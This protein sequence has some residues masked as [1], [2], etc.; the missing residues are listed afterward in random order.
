VANLT[1][2][3]EEVIGTHSSL[4]LEERE[5]EDL[6]VNGFK[7]RTNFTGQIIVHD[8]FE[9][10][11]V[12]VIGPW[13]KHSKALV[14]DALLAVLQDVFLEELKVCFVSVDGVSQVVKLKLFLWV[15]DERSNSL[16]AG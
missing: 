8:V 14:L 5:P 10:D 7:R 13:M 15:T 3:A 6:S 16:D 12:E 11:F 4:A 9:I 2:G 1:E